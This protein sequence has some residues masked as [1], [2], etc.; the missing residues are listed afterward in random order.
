MASPPSKPRGMLYE[1]KV[2]LRCPGKVAAVRGPGE[3]YSQGAQ[4][5]V[6]F[7][8]EAFGTLALDDQSRIKAYFSQKT[9]VSVGTW[10]S[11]TDSAVLMCNAAEKALF[12]SMGIMS[13]IGHRF[14]AEQNRKK[15]LFILHMF[16][17]CPCFFMM[18]VPS[19]KGDV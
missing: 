4:L 7:L 8:S 9:D 3:F 2:V 12:A 5:S 16:P 6:H 19:R 17:N 11:G 14:S 18:L 10:C 13:R 1:P 15:Q